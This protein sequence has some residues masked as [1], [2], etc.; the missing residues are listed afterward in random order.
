MPEAEGEEEEEEEEE[1]GMHA[2]ANVVAVQALA[3]NVLR[4]STAGLTMATLTK[5][6]VCFGQ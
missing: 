4:H 5:V 3:S 1:E 2:K 6:V